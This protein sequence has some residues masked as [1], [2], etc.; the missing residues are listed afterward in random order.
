[1]RKS[2]LV[3]VAAALLLLATALPAG[4]EPPTPFV[5]TYPYAQK[6]RTTNGVVDPW[7]FQYGECVSFVAWKLNEAQGVT[8]APWVFQ[9]S[10]TGPNGTTGWWGNGGEWD[11]NARK[12]GYRVDDQPAVGAV[13]Q[14][15]SG[16]RGPDGW[17]GSRGG[18]VAYVVAVNPD[19]SVIVE[20]YN[21]VRPRHTFS[22]RR[23]IAPRYLHIA[24]VPAVVA[25]SFKR[26]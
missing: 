12:L 20:E 4:A 15:R 25:A 22:V 8:A 2:L 23:T 13:A 9:N 3:F 6:A 7:R 16:E 24:D 26:S 17:G 18:H 10:S 21:A 14:W 1:M 11:A 5:D 19:G